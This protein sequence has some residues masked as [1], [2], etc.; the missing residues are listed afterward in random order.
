M[1]RK[2]KRSGGTPNDFNRPIRCGAMPGISPTFYSS[3]DDAILGALEPRFGRRAIG[4]LMQIRR[5]NPEVADLFD[6]LRRFR[7]DADEAAA[8]CAVY[9]DCRTAARPRL[10]DGR[11]VRLTSRR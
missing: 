7:L 11:S 8:I 9:R 3:K 4:F 1:P 2:R 6:V 10:L 5:S